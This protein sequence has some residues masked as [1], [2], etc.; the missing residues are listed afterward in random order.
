MNVLLYIAKTFIIK[1]DMLIMNY[2]NV[3]SIGFQIM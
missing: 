2:T 3:I 1:I